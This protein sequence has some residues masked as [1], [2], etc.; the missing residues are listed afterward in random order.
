MISFTISA[1]DIIL[2]LAVVMLSILYLRKVQSFPESFSFDSIK[3]DVEQQDPSY[4]FQDLL[5]ETLDYSEELDDS[6]DEV[7]VFCNSF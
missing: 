7:S 2:A 3:H 6:E 1:I 4:D 5:P